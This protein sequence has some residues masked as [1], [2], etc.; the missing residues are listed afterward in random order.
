[1]SNDH[2]PRTRGSRTIEFL[3]RHGTATAIVL[4]C[5]ATIV[6]LVAIEL[7]CRVA[8]RRIEARS[9]TEVYD[10]PGFV[11]YDSYLGSAPEKNVQ[12][13]VTRKCRDGREI[14]RARYTIDDQGRRV[15]PVDGSAER[16]LFML[17][18]GC[19]FVFGEGLN[20]DETLPYF[21]ARRAPCYT[22]Y[23]YSFPG[24]GPQQMLAILENG[25]LKSQVKQGR[26]MAIYGYMGEPG[27]GHIDRAIGSML[28]HGWAKHFPH[29]YLDSAGSLRREGDFAS[30][31]RAQ[32]LLYSAL[33]HSA[34]VRL[35]GINHPLWISDDHIRLTA[36]IIQKS[37]EDF[38]RLFRSDAFYVVS[39]PGASKEENGKLM[40]LLKASGV[41]CLDYS[42]LPEFSN[43]GYRIEGDEHP[44]AL[45]NDRLADIIARDLGIGGTNCTGL[46]L[47]GLTNP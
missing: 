20:D 24:Y 28:I 7:L 8:E 11:R 6:L 39:F 12:V 44:S 47:D 3:S 18:F 29:Y 19:S 1:M 4:G 42:A 22:P 5:L 40:S 16:P 17:L 23:N 31:R 36:R 10:R 27:V 9:C 43:K 2:I 15:T 45:W 38:R 26:G 14:F 46:G 32:S 25:G 13:N 34:F 33:G 21:L 37:A 30:G 41:R 35:F